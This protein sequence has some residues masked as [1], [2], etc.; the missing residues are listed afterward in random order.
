M[1]ALEGS[2]VLLS[3]G[4]S[5]LGRALVQRF[6]GEG[7]KVACLEYSTAKVDRLRAEFGDSVLAIEG[8]IRDPAASESAVAEVLRNCGRLDALIGT[9]AIFDNVPAFKL[10]A[11][12][13]ILPAFDEIMRTNVAG[14]ILIATAAREALEAT[15][16]SITF[17]LSTSGMY[18]G[19][20]PMYSASKAALTMVVKQLAFELAPRVRVNGVVPG[21]IRD[22]GIAGPKALDQQDT[23]PS[24]I[25]PGFYD[26]AKCMSPQ[27]TC[28][29]AT[30]YTGIYVLLASKTDAA[31]A[32]GAIINWDTGLGMIGHGM[33]LAP[34]LVQ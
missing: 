24:A 1:G 17:T 5:G 25:F 29:S 22:S 28:P 7:S 2:G 15:G 33:A 21:T 11:R 32:T 6:L 20:G 34:T 18:P 10:Y 9:A 26:A 4:G 19:T 13:H 27:R 8:D 3:G 12:N 16:G 14:H 23:T 30:E 31:V